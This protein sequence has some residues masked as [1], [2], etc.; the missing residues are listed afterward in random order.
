[1]AL[2]V[3]RPPDQLYHGTVQRFLPAIQR[4]GLRPMKRHD[5]HLSAS[6]DTAAQVGSRRGVPV[7][8]EVGARAMVECGHEF[9][10]S[11]NGVWLTGA[12][13]PEFLTRLEG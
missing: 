2:P 8:L 13:P 9:R 7:I 6:R 4:E 1:L 5:V 10:V 11:A 12:V 3:A